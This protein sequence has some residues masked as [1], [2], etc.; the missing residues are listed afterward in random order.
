VQGRQYRLHQLIARPGVHL[1]LER[2]AP[3][4][5]CQFRGPHIHLRRIENWAGRGV[6]AV[7]PDGYV[8]YRSAST[9]VDQICSWLA[10]MGVHQ[11]TQDAPHSTIPAL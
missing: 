9:D 4:P 8:G 6:I 7:R 11:E 5:A 3:E 1:L 2:D 10:T